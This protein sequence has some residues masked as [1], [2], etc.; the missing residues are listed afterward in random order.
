MSNS[1]KKYK[2][3]DKNNKFI[4]SIGDKRYE[5]YYD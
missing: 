3:F 1:N 5:H 4:A 2:V